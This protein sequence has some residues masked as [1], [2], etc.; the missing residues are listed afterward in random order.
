MDDYSINAKITADTSG[1]EKGIK[2]AQTASKNFSNSITGVI[3][4]LGKSGLV[5]SMANLSLAVG[6]LKS[7]FSMIIKVAN[8]VSKAINECTEAYKA[9]LIT[10]RALDTAIENN[11]FV[12]GASSKALKQFA[13]E[14]QKVSNYGDE[15]L[16]PMMANLISLGRTESETMQIMSVA[17][18]MSAGM[19]IS[20]DSAITQLNA[21]LNGN[22]GRL[23]QQNAE[24]KALTE[25]ELKSGKAVEILGNKFKGFASATVDT[26]TQLKNIKGD[27]K[28]ALGQFT[29]PSSDMWNKFWAGFYENGIKVITR[30]NDYLDASIIGKNISKQ[31]SSNAD[32][33]AQAQGVSR[34]DVLSDLRYLKEQIK[35]LNDEELKAYANY[36]SSLNKRTTAE[37]RQLTIAKQILQARGLQ[38]VQAKKEAE[39]EAQKLKL[40]ETESAVVEET[41]QKEIKYSSEYQEKLL[42]QRIGILEK[43]RDKELENE[44]ITQE[45][46]VEIA[47][48]YENI[49]LAMR[50]KQ[51]E[52]ARKK[53]LSAENITEEER[54]AINTFYDNEIVALREES[55]DKILSI[56]KKQTKKEEADEK[57]KFA[58]M[59]KVAQDYAKNI[60][61]VFKK[62]GET[63]GKTFSAIGSFVKNTFSGL[64]NIFS[65]LFEFN[66]SDAL[67]SLLAV[68]DAILTFF[69]ETLPKLP[70]FFESAFSSVLVLINTLVSAIDWEKVKDVVSSMVE[71]FVKYAPDIVSG[72]VD[73]FTGLFDTISSVLVDKAPEIVEAFKEMFFAVLE[74]LPS[75]F[76]NVIEVVGTFIVELGKAIIDNADRLT[77]D[78][79]AIVETI[80]T[81]ISDFVEGGGWKTILDAIITI[82]NAIQ[83]V[84]TDNL[85]D[86]VNVIVDMLPDFI[87][88]LEESIVSA[89]GAMGKILKPLIKLVLAVVEA[90]IDLLLSDE[91]LDAGIEAGFTIMDTI[92]EELV[93]KLAELI[94]KLIIKIIGFIVKNIPKIV[95]AMV[96]GLIKSFTSFP[97]V[98]S[99]KQMFKGFID[100]IKEFFGIHSPSTVF[101]DFGN[102]MIEGLWQGIK[103]MGAWLKENIVGFFTDFWDSITGVFANIGD[104]FGE[105]FSTATENIKSA[106]EGIGD[107]FSETFTN[108]RDKVGEA[109]ETI[110]D[111]AGDRWQDIKDGF[112]NVGDWF[113]DTFSTA[114]TNAKAGFTKVSD[115]AIDRWTDIKDGFSSVGKWFGD[116]FST[117]WDKVKEAWKGA[118]DWFSDVGDGIKDIFSKCVT[119]MKSAFT[120]AGEWVKDMASK[121]GSGLSKAGEAIKDGASWVGNKIK[122][123][124]GFANGTNNAPRGLALVGEAG[125]ELVRFN[126][127]EQVLNNRNTNKALADMGK[128]SSVFNVTFNNTQDTTAFAMMSQLKRYQRNLAFNGVL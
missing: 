118:K 79:N 86:I 89:S 64:K 59:L 55:A 109:F 44:E 62:I 102:F 93:P 119:N 116:T 82:Q 39:A 29:L 112:S 34:E 107:W 98:Q 115:W 21:T 70:A 87:D 33:V 121:I 77:E 41:A 83:T 122:D 20:L 8:D 69:V 74:A 60:G 9:Q 19:G 120:K 11:P 56:K 100:G 99:I 52:D 106:F 53:A 10:E 14:M 48:Y 24:L 104:W 95:K 111:W 32:I 25:E 92:F 105:K 76:S 66:V 15:E 67:D 73:L 47:E 45:Q 101:E 88:F 90:I 50:I 81:G 65:K 5:G 3:N 23:G 117:A 108:A 18:D 38:E 103:D 28:E 16:I 128:G 91:V 46:R 78:L 114:W 68:E 30:F 43:T 94:P 63:I 57:S 13:S 12:T 126:G 85:E 54:L 75:I 6:G 17:M 36:L 127:G 80:V 26:S 1:F 31:M 97:W 37:E 58:V 40:M 2:K 96:E 72:I 84:I 71:T 49:I 123:F 61:K 113:S 7:S 125:P 51:T 42:E 27:F 110:G 4:K 22:I 35:Y 124:F